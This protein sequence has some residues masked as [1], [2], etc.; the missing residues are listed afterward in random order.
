MQVVFAQLSLWLVGGQLKLK[1][2]KENSVRLAT[3]ASPPCQPGLV[4]TPLDS[5]HQLL[6]PQPPLHHPCLSV[7]SS[8]P[9]PSCEEGEA[10]EEK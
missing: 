10:E 5:P 7:V 2:A 9:Q 4:P 8:Q 6:L 3:A 1:G